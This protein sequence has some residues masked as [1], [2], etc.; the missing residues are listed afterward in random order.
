MIASAEVACDVGRL[1]RDCAS[2]LDARPEGAPGR[3]KPV[4][5]DC[6]PS[7]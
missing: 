4:P 1:P 2:I 6:F 5:Y 3:D 7:V